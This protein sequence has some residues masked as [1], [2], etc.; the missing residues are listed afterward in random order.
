[1]Y[2]RDQL[3]ID[4]QWSTPDSGT[5]IDV[6]SPHSQEVIGRV[7]FAGPADVDRAVQAARTAFD[8]GPWPRMQPAERIAAVTRLAE[9]YKEH[10]GDMAEL[11][12]A[13]IG[14]PISFAKRAQV[15]IPLMMFSAF[16][17]LEAAMTGRRHVRACTATTSAFSSSRSEWLR[18]LCRGTCRSSSPSAR[19]SRRCWPGAVSCS[20]PL[21]NRCSTLSYSQTWCSKPMVASQRRCK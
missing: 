1:M 19:S 20:S 13:E 14:A 5:A 4:G 9:L 16:C 10:R 3:F 17:D 7:S 12:T 8:G 15:R 2:Y 18:R 11:I 21:P 6:I